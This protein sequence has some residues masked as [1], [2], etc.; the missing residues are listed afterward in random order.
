MD[1]A[2]AAEVL[3]QARPLARPPADA[4]VR[5]AVLREDPAVAAR[6]DTELDRRPPSLFVAQRPVALERDPVDDPAAQPGGPRDPAVDAVRAD[7]DA[8]VDLAPADRERGSVR[9]HR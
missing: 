8:P 3:A 4:V 5:V 1:V 2:E 9:S 7:E 6:H